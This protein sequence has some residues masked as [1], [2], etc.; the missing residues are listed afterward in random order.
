[1]NSLGFSGREKL[2]VAKKSFPTIVH[3]E[4]ENS[5]Q[6]GYSI[7]HSTKFSLMQKAPVVL[8]LPVAKWSI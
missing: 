5:F 2:N 3:S 8:S 1:M 4:M 6:L 7:K